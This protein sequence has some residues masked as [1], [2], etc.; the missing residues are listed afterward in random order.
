MQY[1]IVEVVALDD[2][3]ATELMEEKVGEYLALGW[4]PCGGLA[5]VR[6]ERFA[7]GFDADPFTQ[8][9]QAVTHPDKDAPLP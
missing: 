1:L 9:M 5:V 2:M 4:Q 7:R 8:L 3:E 6:H